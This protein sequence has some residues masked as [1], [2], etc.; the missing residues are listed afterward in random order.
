MRRPKRPT[1]G[2]GA[3]GKIAGNGMD[4]RNFEQFARAKR[5]QNQGS[6]AASID[7]PAPGGP[8]SSRLWPPAAAISSARWHSPDL[9]VAQIRQ[10]RRQSA[11][12]GPRPRHDLRAFEMIG[13]LNQRNRRDTSIS[14]S[15]PGRLRA[16]LARA[17][18]SVATR[19]RGD[20]S[21]QYTGD[22]GDRPVE[23]EFTENG[24]ILQSVRS[25]RADRRHNAERD[26]QIVMAAL[27]GRSAGA[28]LTVTLDV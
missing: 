13:E 6:R 18:Q 3:A 20:R 7:L 9:Y 14:R 17:D 8:F 11:H 23:C 25:Y 22:R 10:C 27:F 21:R 5:R 28:R 15:G 19:I 2:E 24:I 1:I 26:R 16:A 12:R 4:Q